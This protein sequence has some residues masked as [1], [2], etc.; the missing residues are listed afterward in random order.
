[1]LRVQLQ[2]MLHRPPPAVHG[3]AGQAVDQVQGEVFQ[4]GLAGGGNSTVPLLHRVGAAGRFQLRRTGR[5]HPQGDP[6]EARPPQA[7]QRPGVGAVRVG[8]K[9]DFRVLLHTVVLPDRR[10]QLLQPL[11]A[12]VAGRAAP[13]IDRVY[14]EAPGGQGR[15]LQ[16]GQQGL[17]IAVHPP[18][19]ARKG[20]EIAVVAL[21]AAKWYVDVYPQLA[22]RLLVLHWPHL[23][24]C[25]HHYSKLSPA[26]PED[27][28]SNHRISQP[29]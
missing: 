28:L 22:R 29:P 8:F 15:L 3:L 14:R 10:Q 23:P 9:G 12:I 1:M 21:A 13:K 27:F 25:S 18:L 6:V 19:L 2:N 4:L 20:V 7:P 26:C 24:L 17:L 5:L 16:M 11:S